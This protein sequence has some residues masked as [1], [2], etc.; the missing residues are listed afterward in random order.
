M[1]FQVVGHDIHKDAYERKVDIS[2]TAFP[3]LIR[4]IISCCREGVV[5]P[6]VPLMVFSN[7]FE[8]TPISECEQLWKVFISFRKDFSSPLFISKT[9]ANTNLSILAIVNS[10][11][12]R[13]S[14]M[15]YSS[16]RGDLMMWM[17]HSQL[18]FRFLSNVFPFEERS[19]LNVSNRY[20]IHTPPNM[21]SQDTIKKAIM[22]AQY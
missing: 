17:L 8:T 4:N 1:A 12:K 14:R 15:R 7:C 2:T 16:F 19:G 3:Q 22:E 21:E 9:Q 18:M 6:I 20:N 5:S 11:L 10:L 13:A